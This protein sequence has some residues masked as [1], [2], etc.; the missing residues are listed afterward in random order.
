MRG[1]RGWWEGELLRFFG[2]HTVLPPA[3]HHAQDAQGQPGGEGR[4]DQQ[5]HGRAPL[6][7]KKE[8]HHRVLLVVQR[9]GKQGKKNGCLK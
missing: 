2:N 6:R 3:R 8:V 4:Q 1:C 7:A 9:K 5:H